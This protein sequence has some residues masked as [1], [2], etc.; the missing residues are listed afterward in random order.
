MNTRKIY[1]LYQGPSGPSNMSQ[2]Y[3]R[4][5]KQIWQV[6][7]VSVKQAIYLCAKE[8]WYDGRENQT[9]I[10]AYKVSNNDH[11]SGKSWTMW[12][13]VADRSSGFKHGQSFKDPVA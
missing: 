7:A 2:W 9:G 10:I 4:F 8:V 12:D 3:D 5:S 1:E 11:N 6:A 13:G